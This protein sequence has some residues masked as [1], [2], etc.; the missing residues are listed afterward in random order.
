MKSSDL[1][2]V[3][4]FIDEMWVI[5]GPTLCAAKRIK[6]RPHLAMWLRVRSSENVSPCHSHH[7]HGGVHLVPTWGSSYHL[8]FSQLPFLC[9]AAWKLHPQKWRCCWEESTCCREL[10]SWSGTALGLRAVECALGEMLLWLS[11][12]WP[13]VQKT[14]LRIFSGMWLIQWELYPTASLSG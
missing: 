12:P 1:P 14:C 3:H 10:D 11:S 7:H 9:K 2:L 4:F 8:V 6:W 5:I 13:W